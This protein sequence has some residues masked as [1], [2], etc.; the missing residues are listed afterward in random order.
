MRHAP[1]MIRAWH[2]VKQAPASDCTTA[3]SISAIRIKC[4]LVVPKRLSTT[5]HS[6]M[7]LKVR[8]K[9]SLIIECLKWVIVPLG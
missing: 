1:T 4:T 2:L 8:I 7:L 6:V 3:A 5:D 9:V